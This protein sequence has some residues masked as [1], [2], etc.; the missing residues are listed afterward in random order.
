MN[1][2]EFKPDIPEHLLADLDP[3]DR[4][5]H[6]Q[7]SITQQMVRHVASEQ[8]QGTAERRELIDCVRGI[9]QKAEENHTAFIAH[10]AA[11]AKMFGEQAEWQQ[12]HDSEVKANFAALK[13]L[14]LDTYFNAKVAT[15]LILAV[16]TAVVVAVA[17][18]HWK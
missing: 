13:W 4:W 17:M 9:S 11:D 2:P 5:L 1:L 10:V 3:K 8:V 6:E 18:K 16:V 14:R 12:K 15:K 7:S